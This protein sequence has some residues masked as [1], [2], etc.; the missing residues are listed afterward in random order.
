MRG[1]ELKGWTEQG[2]QASANGTGAFADALIKA[3]PGLPVT[4]EARLQ[5]PVQLEQF[6]AGVFSWHRHHHPK[7]A[8]G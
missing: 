4:D 2:N 1:H 3:Y 7:E 5:D 6:I 8:P